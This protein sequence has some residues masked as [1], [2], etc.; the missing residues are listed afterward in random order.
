V[1][2]HYTA[3]AGRL[4]IGIDYTSA[5]R[6][7]AGI[8]RYTRNLVRGVAEIDTENDYV[9]FVAGGWGAGDGL[10]TWPSNFQIRSVPFSERSMQILWQRLRLPI[11][12]QALTGPLDLFH[13]P[14]FVLPPRAKM[15]AVLTVH[16]LSFIRVPDCFVPGFRSYLE[17]AVARSVRRADLI[18]ADSQNTKQDLVELMRVDPAQVTVL[19]PGVEACFC[20]VRDEEVLMQ[21]RRRYGLPY[22]F[23]LGLGTLQPRKNFR[24]LV[25]GFGCLLAA[26][27]RHT[28]LSRLV[29][30]LQLVVVGGQGWMFEDTLAAV[31]AEGLRQR[32]HFAGFVEDRDLAAVYSL[33]VAFAFP[34]WYEGFG[35]PVLEAMACGTPVVVSDNSSLPEVVGG[36]GLLVDAADSAALADA[37]LKILADEPLRR[38]LGSR[39]IERAK[40]FSWRNSAEQLLDVYQAMGH[41]EV[42][43]GPRVSGGQCEENPGG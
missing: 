1:A 5:V 4:R 25:E 6:Q 9:L 39:G 37:L 13:A 41:R 43:A 12:I 21:V 42:A 28:A 40:R 34:S 23:I 32:V 33:A 29:D 36:A 16:D 7:R 19:Y 26:G 10:G 18:L 31:E 24:G 2:R 11:P 27:S 3:K 20:P 14:D 15:P 22:R 35:L 30:D 8:G 38:G 17:R